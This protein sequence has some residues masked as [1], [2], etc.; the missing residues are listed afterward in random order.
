[1][2][3][4]I[5]QALASGQS[6]N[7]TA[8]TARTARADDVTKDDMDDEDDDEMDDLANELAA[9]E[10][11]PLNSIDLST[12]N[13]EMC[14]DW[15]ISYEDTTTDTVMTLKPDGSFYQKAGNYNGK[16]STKGH[17][18][19][20]EYTTLTLPNESGPIRLQAEINRDLS[21]FRGTKTHPAYKQGRLIY[22]GVRLT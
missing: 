21:V 19:V 20:L 13:I 8:A 5:V 2:S 16:W 3:E 11:D 18:I 4:D 15:N 17:L 22:V 1:M 6:R 7:F 12:P 14:G 9:L 10:V